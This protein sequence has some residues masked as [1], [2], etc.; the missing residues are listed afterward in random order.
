M[1]TSLNLLL[2]T[3]LV[4]AV[5]SIV[6]Q[7]IIQQHQGTSLLSKVRARDIKELQKRRAAATDRVKDYEKRREGTRSEEAKAAAEERYMNVMAEQTKEGRVPIAKNPR[8]KLVRS[9]P[10]MKGPS[11]VTDAPPAPNPWYHGDQFGYSP[12]GFTSITNW[13]VPTSGATGG[14]SVAFFRG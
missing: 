5:L 12:Y 11:A 10:L 7:A 14:S 9:E 2:A 4:L 13:N 6:S 8:D 1:S 3:V